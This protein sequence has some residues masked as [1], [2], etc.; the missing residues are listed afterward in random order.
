[1]KY[2][3]E[4]EEFW[5]GEFGLNYIDRNKSDSL[6]YSVVS[7]WG[8]MLRATN[9]IKSAREF[10]CNIGLNLMAL[11]K[12]KP[13]IDLSAYEIN[14]QAAKQAEDLGIAQIKLGSIFFPPLTKGA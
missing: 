10:G 11:K 3:T 6:F 12:L 7:M 5:A 9:N 2:K 1:M 8:K 13:M 14:K 4:Q